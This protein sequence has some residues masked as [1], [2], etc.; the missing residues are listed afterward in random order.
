MSLD[1]LDIFLINTIQQDSVN[2]VCQIFVTDRPNAFISVKMSVLYLFF[3]AGVLEI[4]CVCLCVCVNA[5]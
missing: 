1:F 3:V 5:S 4:D 2:A